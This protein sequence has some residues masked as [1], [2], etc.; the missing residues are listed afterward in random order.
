MLIPFVL[1][2]VGVGVFQFGSLGGG[3]AKG[4]GLILKSDDNGH[5]WKNVSI[6]ADRKI[7]FPSG[8]FSMTFHPTDTSLI[9]LGTRGSGLWKSGDGGEIWERVID[10][11]GVL[12]KFSDV[13]RV[14]IS[15]LNPNIMYIAVFQDGKGR[16]LRSEDGGISFREV[17]FVS[18]SR[19]TVSDVSVDLYDS[20]HIWMTTGQGGLLESRNGGNSWRV[21][22]W[23]SEALSRILVN[24]GSTRE[25]Y[26]VTSSKKLFK[27]LDGGTN[28]V[29]LTQN[30]V[31]RSTLQKSDTT[32]FVPQYPNPQ[33][34]VNPFTHR[35][36][37]IETLIMD[38]Q[39][40]NT[41][42]VGS[43]E[44]ILKSEDGGVSWRRLNVLIPPEAL[45][46]EDVAIHPLALQ[47]I[48]AAAGTQLHQSSDG[49]I[50]WSLK[51]LPIKS[52]IRLLR[53]HPQKP[54]NMFVVLGQ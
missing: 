11:S 1:S 25:I 12:D 10:A 2:I 33:F 8:I 40:F 39:R 32:S 14:S 46:V 49:G 41:L 38:P 26:L 22:K 30:L 44:G 42:Y 6:S 51:N 52:R 53:I 15:H 28:W 9:F 13:Y 43:R 20:N 5:T 48:F 4:H 16:L 24:P 3:L 45:P 31:Q 54:Q 17:Y 34:V 37:N 23:F 18:S 36:K 35:A 29:D 27:S 19:A 21:V 7:K 50:N 47:V